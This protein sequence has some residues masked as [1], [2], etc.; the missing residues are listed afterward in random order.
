MLNMTS[1]V[2]SGCQFFKS[3]YYTCVFELVN[4]LVV[5]PKQMST[6]SSFFDIHL[7]FGSVQA[8]GFV[9]AVTNR[10]RCEGTCWIL[11]RA[12]QSYGL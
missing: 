12:E 2:D 7:L 9:I 11:L 5:I 3:L 6:F 8:M 10:D 1:I 4:L